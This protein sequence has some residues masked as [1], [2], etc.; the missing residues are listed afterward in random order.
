MKKII[1]F[2]IFILSVNLLFGQVNIAKNKPLI[3]GSYS[4]VNDGNIQ[5]G[6]EFYCSNYGEICE[7]HHFIIDFQSNYNVNSFKLYFDSN[8]MNLCE[9]I[10]DNGDPLICHYY[11]SFSPDNIN[12]S[13]LT[14]VTTSGQS[15]N[16]IGNYRYVKF[17]VPNILDGG[18]PYLSELEVYSNELSNTYDRLGNYTVEKKI[19]IGTTFPQEALEINGNI[20][21]NING[22]LRINTGNGYLDLGPQNFSEANLNTDRSIFK[23]NKPLKISTSSGY[24]DLGSLNSNEANISTD[25]SVFMFNKAINSSSSTLQLATNGKSVNIGSYTDASATFSVYKSTIPYFRLRSDVSFLE[26]GMATCVGCFAPGARSGD[27]VFRTWNG[28]TKSILLYIPT[29]ENSADKYIGISDDLNGV[30][31]KFQSNRQLRVDGTIYTKELNVQ[32]NVWAD[33]VFNKDYKLK[34]LSELEKYIK[35]NNHLPEIPSENDVITN[36]LKVGEM[37]AL[38]LKKIEELTLYLIEMKNEN[39]DLKNRII[40]LEKK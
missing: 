8:N 17:S 31:A 6:G 21:G 2:L 1:T 4:N 25:R 14:E 35:E 38:L 33:H 29:N 10:G 15:Y 22:A 40:K 24:I 3:N 19:G 32:L 13:N 23:F 36:G 18:G 5:T 30:W 16:V 11:I 27:A 9:Y 12:W 37:N 7:D 20:R 28:P 39:E 26:I 34:S